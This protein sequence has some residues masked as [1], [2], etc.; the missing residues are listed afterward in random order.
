MSRWLLALVLALA[1]SAIF[2]G[3]AFAD[4]STYHSNYTSTTR[5]CAG[6]HR[7]HTGQGVS[8]IKTS[9]TYGLCTSCHGT[10]NGLDVVDGAEWETDANHVRIPGTPPTEALKGGGF[11]NTLMN[12]SQ[13][14]S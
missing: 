9:G 13:V 11:L 7:A 5:A 4:A 8:L 3:A 12:T 6:C 1:V 14:G 10:T 2:A